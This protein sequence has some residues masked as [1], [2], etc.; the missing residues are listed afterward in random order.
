[1]RRPRKTRRSTDRQLQRQVAAASPTAR[2]F[3][4]LGHR[5]GSVNPAVSASAL[6]AMRA[7]IRELDLR[8]ALLAV[9]KD[10][11]DDLPGMIA[12]LEAQARLSA[13][14]QDHSEHSFYSRLASVFAEFR[15]GLTTALNGRRCNP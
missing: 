12:E 6:K 9:I 15:N 10:M 1:V 3:G 4:V 5:F 11:L 2:K 7:T 8:A 14:D 13:Q